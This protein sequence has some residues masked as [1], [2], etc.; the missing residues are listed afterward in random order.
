MDY[1]KAY[2][3]ISKAVWRYAEEHDE[4]YVRLMLAVREVDRAVTDETPLP[5][6]RFALK[7]KQ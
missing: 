1:R 5:P 7:D 4:A 6:V 3:E 2:E